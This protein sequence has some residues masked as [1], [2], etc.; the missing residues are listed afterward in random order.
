MFSI[1]RL[2]L[3]LF[4]VVTPFNP[5]EKKESNKHVSPT[6]AETQTVYSNRVTL[7]F[8]LSHIHHNESLI[9]IFT[10]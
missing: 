4:Y 7:N 10:S 6:T 5:Q 2:I 3:S 8:L 1:K 9:A